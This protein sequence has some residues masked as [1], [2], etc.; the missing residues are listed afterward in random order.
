MYPGNTY[1]P[2]GGEPAYGLWLRKAV[3]NTVSLERTVAS[4]MGRGL[5]SSVRM[6]NL[7]SRANS[8][9]TVAV[10]AGAWSLVAWTE[11]DPANAPGDSNLFLRLTG[12]GFDSGSVKVSSAFRRSGWDVTLIIDESGR[13]RAFWDE[14]SRPGVNGV[15]ANGQ[16]VVQPDVG[17]IRL[18]AGRHLT[19]PDG[20]GWRFYTRFSAGVVRHTMRRLSAEHGFGPEVRVDDP[21]QGSPVGYREASGQDGENF[22]TVAFQQVS[23]AQTGCLAVRRMLA[24]VL[25][26]S[27]CIEV[28]G[29]TMPNHNFFDLTTDPS[30]HALL[31]WSTG[32]KD[33]A[34]Y[35]ARRGV[36]G[37]WSSPVKLT[38]LTLASNAAYSWLS[39]VLS[40]IDS[41]GRALVALR[42]NNQ[43][44][45][46]PTI[47]A[48]IGLED[49][50]WS[51]PVELAQLGM[52][53]RDMSVAFNGQ[54]VPGVLQ[55]VAQL[56]GSAAVMMSTWSN[57]G[58]QSQ[59]LR[60]G[61]QLS[62]INGV[63]LYTLRL[64]PQGSNGW[65]AL[66]DEG[67]G[68]N[69]STGYRELWAAEYR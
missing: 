3:D 61:T 58:W 16:W 67:L 5:S 30:G 66:W 52:S 53:S 59:I 40:R 23:G 34:L 60:S 50:S 15:F 27:D 29:E 42:L 41:N 35:G 55:L 32:V 46:A 22:T 54:G 63:P 28:S 65:L 48:L 38:D 20:Q 24:G 47:R 45:G 4:S 17:D 33:R 1:Q 21:A 8:N 10:V 18:D 64:T 11:Y 19:S 2:L 31:T 13:A 14:D 56:D 43:A 68:Y 62:Y 51:N 49:G 37:L 25:Q 39:G 57:G 44:W 26:A 36:N 69:D 12:T 9:A 6:A 7:P